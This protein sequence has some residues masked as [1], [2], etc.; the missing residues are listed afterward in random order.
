[1]VDRMLMTGNEAAGTP[2]EPK[3]LERSEGKA[4]RVLDKRDIE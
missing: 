1:M 2:G 3:A 4:R